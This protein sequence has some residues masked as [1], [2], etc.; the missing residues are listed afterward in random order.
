MAN[1]KDLTIIL[2]AKDEATGVLTKFTNEITNRF[3]TAKKASN[4]VA[5]AL[6]G[7]GTAAAGFG[8]MAV[9]A[10][11]EAE[12]QWAIVGQ[13][14]KLSGLDYEKTKQQVQ[15]F[16]TAQQKLTGY[17]DEYVATV[18]GRLLP[19]VKDFA[20]ASELAKLALDIEA[21]GKMSAET[22]TRALSF[23]NLGNVDAL[24]RLVPELKVADS[25]TLKN[26]TTEERARLAVE[27][28]KNEYGGLSNALGSSFQGQLNRLKETWGDFLELIGNKI[29]P[30]LMV[31][32]ERA[33]V[34]IGD[35][36]PRWIE[37]TN[38]V[39][40]WMKEHQVIIGAVAGAI[41]GALIPAFIGLATTLFT[42]IIPAL[43]AM[44]LALAPYII[45]GAIIG[46]IVAGVYWVITHWDL[47][48]M[49][50][51]EVW[52]SIKTFFSSIWENI[53]ITFDNAINWILD[54]LT[55]FFNAVDKVRSAASS[56]GAAW[57]NLPA[58]LGFSGGKA[59]GGPVSAG[60]TYLVGERGPELFTPSTSGSIIP[61]NKLGGR[62]IVINISGN[63]I[64]GAGGVKEL[65][66][67]IGKHLVNTLG[68]NNQ[69]V[70]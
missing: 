8:V 61:N 4:Y 22:A 30:V 54:K 46:G 69:I 58:N 68:L 15:D 23:A 59:I 19:S 12:K 18:V 51:I 9:K 36:L 44:A 40:T 45:G 20:K 57:T 41:V 56:V 52:T 3:D 28:L 43:A 53:K 70:Y 37:K 7:A 38:E 64:N 60:S 66:D 62:S 55:P 29:I 50:T 65:A 63:N 67:A 48:K 5:I 35:V 6:A 34:F 21:S 24:K 11:A 26:M 25:E 27:A 2:K 42:T 10:A 1:E 14:I 47:V 16:A 17:S 32:L 49:K 31:L 33:N 13:Q 39:I